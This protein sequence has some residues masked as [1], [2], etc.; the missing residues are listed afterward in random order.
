MTDHPD[1]FFW[2]DLETT[3]LDPQQDQ[4]LEVAAIVT[5][6]DLTT[7]ATFHAVVWHNPQK[8]R[9]S[10]FVW[11]MHTDNGLL[12]EVGK[13]HSTAARVTKSKSQDWTVNAAPSYDVELILEQFVRQYAS[14]APMAGSSVAFDRGFY[15][16]H[17]SL[18]ESALH[19]RNFD[20]SVY[21]EAMKR[22]APDVELPAKSTKHRAMEDIQASIAQAQQWKDFLTDD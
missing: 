14:G 13:D 22:W 11:K 9:M 17:F 3:G 20:V 12:E 8:L 2:T 5:E 21:R 10:S 7:V 6:A 16:R 1:R 15:K 19:Y 4:I 18:V